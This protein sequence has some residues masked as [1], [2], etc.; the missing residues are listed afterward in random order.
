M[1]PRKSPKRASFKLN[2]SPFNKEQVTWVIFKFGELT[3]VK[4]VQRAFRWE[5]CPKNPRNVP[6][7]MTFKRRWIDLKTVGATPDQLHHKGQNPP[8]R[9]TSP[10]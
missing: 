6:N 5:F 7:Y 3:N 4:K 8:S 10:W 9:R 1:P 2:T